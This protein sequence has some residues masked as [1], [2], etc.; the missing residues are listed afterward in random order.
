MKWSSLNW[1]LIFLLQFTTPASSSRINS[2]GGDQC[3][4]ATSYAFAA[5]RAVPVSLLEVLLMS[6]YMKKVASPGGVDKNGWF[7]PWRGNRSW[8]SYYSSGIWR[9][10]WTLL[11]LLTH[12]LVR[13]ILL[14]Y[15][16]SLP[17]FL[18]QS[19]F[20]F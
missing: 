19:Q 9:S 20:P 8:K 7:T 11:K 3:Q 1:F 10:V 5:D 18:S 14:I 13:S 6:C 12:N 2:S 17:T 4:P 16:Y 15:H